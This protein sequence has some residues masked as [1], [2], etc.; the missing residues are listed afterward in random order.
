MANI[1]WNDDDVDGE[2]KENVRRHEHEHE[3]FEYEY[4]WGYFERL[5][6]ES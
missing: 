1:S 6:V 3:S 4:R 2:T 5:Q